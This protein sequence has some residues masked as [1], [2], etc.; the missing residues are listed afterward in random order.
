M[1]QL[2]VWK[3]DKLDACTVGLRKNYDLTVLVRECEVT[4]IVCQWLYLFH[5]LT[6]PDCLK[7]ESGRVE[8]AFRAAQ[9]WIDKAFQ[10]PEHLLF[11]SQWILSSSN[12]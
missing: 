1:T 10:K 7:E 3:T 11:S 9:E 8:S 4:P 5:L 2:Y 12:T 6:H